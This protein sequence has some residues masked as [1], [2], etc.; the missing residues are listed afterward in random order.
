MRYSA[1]QWKRFLAWAVNMKIHLNFDISETLSSPRPPWALIQA[2]KPY[3]VHRATNKPTTL[4]PHRL[5]FSISFYRRDRSA[6]K[7]LEI[8]KNLNLFFCCSRM[9]MEI[10]WKISW[11]ILFFFLFLFYFFILLFLRRR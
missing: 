1:E 8:S 7:R 10:S 6:T 4:Q 9:N 11:K 5:S 3:N 2:R